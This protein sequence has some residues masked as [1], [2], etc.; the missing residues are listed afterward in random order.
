MER[1]LKL[2]H[3]QLFALLFGLP[4][5]LEILFFS[6]SFKN[7]IAQNMDT[8]RF[9]ELFQ[10]L[11]Y[12]PILILLI[13]IINFGW[14]WAVGINLQQKIPV[15]IRLKTGMFKIFVIFPLIYFVAI[16]LALFW[17]FS[18]IGILPYGTMQTGET[19]PPLIGFLP[20]IFLPIH[21]FYLFCTIYCMYFTART[22][23]TA[24]LQKAVRFDEFV[25]EFFLIMF[26]PI[27]VWIL[28]PRLN[29]MVAEDENAI[30]KPGSDFIMK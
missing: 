15:E 16:I 29:K 12:F 4:I 22:I 28:Q 21:F 27:G 25:G 8:S 13:M 20:L 11:Q 7:M 9:L 17:F 23:K 14:Y 24:E 3:W 6:T 5:V 2:K 1:F 30:Y 26:F 10:Y 19:I 18:I